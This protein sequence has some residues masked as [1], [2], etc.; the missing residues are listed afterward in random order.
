MMLCDDAAGAHYRSRQGTSAEGHAEQ[1]QQESGSHGDSAGMSSCCSN[2]PA[3]RLNLSDIG[4]YRC[5]C[6]Q[7]APAETM[8]AVVHQE[9]LLACLPICAYL[10]VV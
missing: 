7:H 3:A 10:G 5:Q 2:V 6:L 1:Q 9:H 8:L 4:V